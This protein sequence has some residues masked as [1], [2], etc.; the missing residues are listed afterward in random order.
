MTDPWGFSLLQSPCEWWGGGTP[1]HAPCLNLNSLLCSPICDCSELPLC[2]V[3]PCS[4]GRYWGWSQTA[5][6]GPW[7]LFWVLFFTGF[8][9]HVTQ[10]KGVQTEPQ[11][12]L[13]GAALSLRLRDFGGQA[14]L[15]HW[16]PVISSSHLG[17]CDLLCF[18]P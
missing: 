17:L 5:K 1:R 4:A 6:Q 8:R 10:Y 14:S 18:R 12:V 3:N 7:C 11:A 13:M 2:S 16:P 15:G 9:P